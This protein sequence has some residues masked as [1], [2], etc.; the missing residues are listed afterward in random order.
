MFPTAKGR[1]ISQFVSKFK[2]QPTKMKYK[3]DQNHFKININI[4]S[5]DKPI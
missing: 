2:T 5:N 4:D 1:I 3:T